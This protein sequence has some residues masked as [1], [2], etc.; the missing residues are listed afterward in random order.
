[1]RPRP[2]IPLSIR[3]AV[4]ERQYRDRQLETEEERLR[5]MDWYDFVCSKKPN[6]HKLFFLLH[7]IFGKGEA[8][9]DHDP[10]L[11]L[12]KFNARTGR[13]T[14]DAN[15]PAYLIY[16]EKAE[17]QQKT[18]GRRPGASRTVTTKGSDIGLKAKF[19]KLEKRTKASR[20]P[21]Q[22]IPSR[23]FPDSKRGF[24]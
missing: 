4:A 10:A 21:K 13:Y 11:I 23:P 16:R 18:T 5:S 7:V 6:G 12:R 2:Y 9:L 19:A 17:H 14:P 1:M 20:R 22:K 24:R 8:Q 15:D 3:V